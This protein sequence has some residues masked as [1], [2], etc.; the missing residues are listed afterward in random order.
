MDC[1]PDRI[2][3]D[4][5]CFTH[6]GKIDSGILANH[7]GIHKIYYD[8]RGVTSV[9]PTYARKGESIVLI[10]TF[11][12]DAEIYFRIKNPDGTDFVFS[13]F[14]PFAAYCSE[15]D[16]FKVTIKIGQT[17]TFPCENVCCDEPINVCEN[18]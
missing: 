16:L 3:L 5:G 4:V 17:I 10:N 15:H 18:D 8:F 12:E 7:S 9:V 14:W 13:K 2:V 1:K 11:N 6:C